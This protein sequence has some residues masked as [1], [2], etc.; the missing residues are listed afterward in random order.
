MPEANK[1]TNIQAGQKFNPSI[2]HRFQKFLRDFLRRPTHYRQRQARNALQWY[3]NRLRITAKYNADKNYKAFATVHSLR[4]GGL[5]QY[6]YDPKWK[7][8]LPYYDKFPLIIPIKMTH[9]GWIGLNVH[10]LPPQLRAVIFDDIVEH[11]MKN[12]NVMM[13]SMAWVEAYKK[14]PVIRG[15]I[16]RYLWKHVTSPLVEIREEEWATI[17]MLPSHVFVKKS[18][19]DVW[20]TELQKHK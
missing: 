10:Y 7:D 20:N 3:F 4:R 16:K 2:L 13:V 8:T 15:A 9:N 19:R 12:K 5:F 6:T 1:P 14:H 17:V 18:A 11:G